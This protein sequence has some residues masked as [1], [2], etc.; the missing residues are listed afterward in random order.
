MFECDTANRRSVAVVCMLYMIRCNPIHP[1]Y[2]ALPIL[3]VPVRLA[4]D[5]LVANRYTYAS[6]RCKTS[7]F[8]RTFIPVSVSLWNDLADDVF[9]G[10]ELAVVK[11]RTNAFLLACAAPSLYVFNCF[12]S[13]LLGRYFRGFVMPGLEYCFAVWCSAADTH[14]KLLDRVASGARFLTGRCLIVTLLIVDVW[15]YYVC[16]NRPSL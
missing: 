2:G 15:Q 8:S 6:S 12:L 13:P 7:L 4:P 9:D 16:C 10:A 14:I 3:Y 11:S 5:A 1:L